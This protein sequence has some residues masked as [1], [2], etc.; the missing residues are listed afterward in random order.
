MIT[1]SKNIAASQDQTSKIRRIKMTKDK[2]SFVPEGEL[3]ILIQSFRKT[4]VNLLEC[5]PRGWRDSCIS[6]VLMLVLMLV[7]HF[8]V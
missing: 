4:V 7:W 3:N 2:T 1:P 5:L 8:K 6:L